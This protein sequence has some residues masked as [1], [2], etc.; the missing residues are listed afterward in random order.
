MFLSPRGQFEVRRAYV[1]G[2]IDASV[3]NIRDTSAV[4]GLFGEISSYRT[5]IY[6]NKSVGDILADVDKAGFVIGAFYAETDDSYPIEMYANLHYGT[7]D[8]GVEK[9]FSVME[10]GGTMKEYRILRRSCLP[11]RQTVIS[12]THMYGP[13]YLCYRRAPSY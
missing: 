5:F 9:V 7:K 1:E 11:V 3:A 13:E 10:L 6:D 4:G 8:A 2:D 12:S